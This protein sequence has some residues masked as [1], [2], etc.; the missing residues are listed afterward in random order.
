M[1]ITIQGQWVCVT[2]SY[3]DTQTVPGTPPTGNPGDPNYDP[4][5]ED[6]DVE[7][8]VETRRLVSDFQK[9]LIL[10]SQLSLIGT[11]IETT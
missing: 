8:E 4:G 2:V 5:T 11:H 10:I 1:A 3:T 6:E 9:H 7:V